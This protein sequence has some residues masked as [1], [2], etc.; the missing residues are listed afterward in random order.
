MLVGTY[1]NDGP[2]RIT[3]HATPPR[4][5]WAFVDF[6]SITEAEKAADELD[7]TYH[8]ERCLIAAM[9]VNN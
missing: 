7:G 6:V 3:V 8:D 9:A 4:K 1:S 2:L 5:V